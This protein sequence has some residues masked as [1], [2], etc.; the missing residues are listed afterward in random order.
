MVE[1]PE[2]NT[3]V[4]LSGTATP[5]NEQ[6]T[7]AID[8]LNELPLEEEKKPISAYFTVTCFVFLTAFGGFVFG[9]DTGTISGFVAMDDFKKRFG[10]YKKSTDEYYLSNVRTGLVVSIFN[11]GCAF[12]SIFLGKLGDMMGRR[13]AIMSVTIIYMVGILI[14]ITSNDK[15]YQ[16]FI[17]RIISGVAVGAISVLCPMMIGETAPRNIRGTLVSIYQ[18]MIT[19]GI[20]LGYCTTYGTKSYSNSAPWRIPLGLCFAFAIL[21]FLGMIIM[22]ESP[23]YLVQVGKMDEARKSLARSSN[24]TADDPAIFKEITDIDNAIQYEKSQGNASWGELISGKPHIFRRVF[25]GVMLQGLQQL[26]GNNYFFYYGTTIFEAVGLEDSFETSI[27]LGVVNFGSTFFGIYIADKIGRR[28]ILLYG[29]VSMFVCFVIFASIGTKSLYPHG[30]NHPDDTSKSV[31]NGMIFLACLFIFCFA[32]TWAPVCFVVI[33]EIYPIRIK[34]KAM[35]L[36]MASNWM[37]GFLI[38]FFTPFITSAIGFAYGYV[39]TGCLVFAAF[40]CYFIVPET[41]GLSLEQVDDLYAADV[42]PWKSEG[43]V[44][45]VRKNNFDEEY[46]HEVSSSD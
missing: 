11:V 4:T 38:S 43:W 28:K 37:W 25:T 30:R 17:G 13:K 8:K 5:V 7:I 33:S 23:R 15:W 10:Q 42:K 9:W 22:P 6:Q 12:G 35:A 41:R 40:F 44:P 31:G 36:A 27:I 26:T 24:T 2:T 32:S 29:A 19:L 18:L 3:P 16:Y 45:P 14:Q 21:L 34:S 39:F 46:K 20:F 1:S